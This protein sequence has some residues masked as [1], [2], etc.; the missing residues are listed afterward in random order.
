MFITCQMLANFKPYRLLTKK[1]M[2]LLIFPQIWH[3]LKIYWKIWNS[4]FYF[5][6]F[7]WKVACLAFFGHQANAHV[8]GF[9]RFVDRVF[10]RFSCWYQY[11]LF[12]IFELKRINE[13]PKKISTICALTWC[14]RSETKNAKCASFKKNLKSRILNSSAFLHNSHP[15]LPIFIQINTINNL[16][17]PH[18]TFCY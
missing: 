2:L 5:K 14:L 16:T 6:V 1:P 12:Q 17:L 4:I 8:V 18:S 3:T 15:N 7:P 13:A 9:Y 10:A 11:L